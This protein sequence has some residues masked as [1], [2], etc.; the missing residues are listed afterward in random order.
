ME[1]ENNGNKIK[2]MIWDFNCTMDKI[3]RVGKNK[4]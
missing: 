1:N 3:G 2:I 4:T